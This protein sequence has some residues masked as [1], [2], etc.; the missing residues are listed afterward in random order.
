MNHHRDQTTAEPLPAYVVRIVEAAN[1]VSHAPLL[2]SSERLFLEFDADLRLATNEEQVHTLRYN[3]NLHP[4]RV[5][6]LVSAATKVQ[7]VFSLP[8]AERLVPAVPREAVLPLRYHHELVRKLSD[9]LPT[10]ALVHHSRELRTGLTRQLT[11]FPLDLRVEAELHEQ[12]A[13]HRV[14]Q[15]A[16]L[17]YQV[18]DFLPTLQ[19]DLRGYVPDALYVASTAMNVAFAE[20][21][22]RLAGVV[23]DAIVRFHTSRPTAELLLHHL[24]EV[25]TPGYAGD[26]ELTDRWADELGLLRWYAWVPL[27]PV[28]R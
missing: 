16:Y 9:Q 3:H 7:R 19:E 10:K 18:A 24:E 22:A 21:A 23:P 6:F 8:P 11:S 1:R 17:R 25:A 27:P 26:R 12:L 20:H 2:V 4:Y 15:A 28:Q 5:H 14:E 13:E